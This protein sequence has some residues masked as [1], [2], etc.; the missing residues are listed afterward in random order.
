[1]RRRVG[2]TALL[3]SI[4]IFAAAV[5]GCGAARSAGA[6]LADGAVERIAARESTL[7]AI[8]QRLVDSLG[9]YLGREFD[10]SVITPARATWDT[11]ARQ[12]RAEAD[13]SAVRLAAS[14]RGRSAK[15]C[16]SCSSGIS[17]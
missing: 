16:R 4:L 14:V 1:M 13:S 3:M 9:A 11:M 8:E 12:V 10:E 7:T 15:R 6:S 5:A 17:T 2:R